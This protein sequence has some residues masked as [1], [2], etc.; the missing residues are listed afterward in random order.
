MHNAAIFR[1]G[2]DDFATGINVEDNHEV[3]IVVTIGVFEVLLFDLTFIWSDEDFYIITFNL[4]D[5]VVGLRLIEGDDKILQATN[6]FLEGLFRAQK[7][8][9]IW[10]LAG[11]NSC[12]VFFLL[13]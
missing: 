2:G 9:R 3:N 5:K 8:K 10:S 1:E 7:F 13:V 12:D 4:I 11:V 6:I